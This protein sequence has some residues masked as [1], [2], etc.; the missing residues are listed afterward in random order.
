[1]GAQNTNSHTYSVAS[2]VGRVK[3]RLNKGTTTSK[4]FKRTGSWAEEEGEGGGRKRGVG[5]GGREEERRGERGRGKGRERR[6]GSKRE[7]EHKRIDGGV[8]HY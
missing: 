4:S 5:R 2:T 1:M 8:I 3:S 7:N 6:W